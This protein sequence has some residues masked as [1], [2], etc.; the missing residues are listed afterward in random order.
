MGL[1]ERE[2]ELAALAGALDEAAAGRGSV[3]LVTGEAGIGKTSLMTRFAERLGGGARLWWGNCDDLAI[4]RPLGPFRDVAGSA[5]LQEALA[6]D[7]PAHVVHAALLEDLSSWPGPTVLVIEDAH[8]ADQATVDAITVV[9]RR[10][11]SLPLLMV[12]TYRSGELGPSHPLP[13]ALDALRASVSH[14][15]ELRPLSRSAVAELAGADADSVYDATGGNPFFVSELVSAGPGELPP[16]VTTAVLGRAARLGDGARRLVELVSMVPTRVPAKVLDRVMPGWPEV[17]EEPE[18]RLLFTVT[19]GHVA[20]RHEL[21]RAAVRSSVP[22]ARRRLLHAELMRALQAVGAD[23]SEVVHHAEEAGDLDVVAEYAVLAA[24]RAAAVDSNREAYS[25]YSRALDFA[26]RLAPAERA[27][28][29]EEAAGAAYTVARL[30]E[31]F[32]SLTRA[33]DL[34]RDV[35]DVAALGR[36]LRVLSRFHWYTGD[37]R[38]ARAA[39]EEAVAA[40]E[41]LGESVE[42]ARAYSG[43]SQLAMLADEYAAAETWGSPTRRSP[44][45]SACRCAPWSTTLRP[46]WRSWGRPAGERRRAA[47]PSWPEGRCRLAPRR[48]EG[49][50]QASRAAA[51]RGT[52]PSPV[53]VRRSPATGRDPTP[54]AAMPLGARW[55]VAWSARGARASEA[56]APRRRPPPPAARRRRGSRAAPSRGGGPLPAGS[57]GGRTWPSPGSSGT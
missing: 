12:L 32:A 15:L 54:R 22:A 53:A 45:A 52:P 23:P 46:C 25:H 4:P 43:L 39:A 33:M 41:P 55:G 20:F 42:L 37:G 11:R 56:R 35:G 28:L 8:W 26:G 24:R 10:T 34:Y 49:P 5:R 2:S 47:S 14:Y 48:T 9:G 27:K 21:A 31:A 30:P 19:P 50:G 38:A 1:L 51:L 16:S 7:A 40:L 13:A 6:H 57:S 36:C 44:C 17:A 18:R 3:V 29:Y